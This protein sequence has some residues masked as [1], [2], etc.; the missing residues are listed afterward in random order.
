LKGVAGLIIK[1]RKVGKSTVLT[2]PS[3]MVTAA[4][5]EVCE[6]QDG[7]II[8]TPTTPNP[9]LD[10]VFVATHD[11]SQKEAFAG[12]MIGNETPGCGSNSGC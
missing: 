1:A 4:E 10:P 7:Q 5:Y 2:V 12:R 3:D 6:G 11:F 8:Y 9:F